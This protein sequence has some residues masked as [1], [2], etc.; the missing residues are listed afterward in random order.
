M[1]L[2]LVVIQS[3]CGCSSDLLAYPGAFLLGIIYHP[4]SAEDNAKLYEHVKTMVDSY[5]LLHPECLVL[6]T[7]DFNPTS[8]NIAPTPFKRSC[9]LTQIINVLTRDSGILD[10]CL[11][12]LEL[13]YDLFLGCTLY[14]GFV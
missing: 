10:W 8:T 4:P 14:A 7:G 6:V 2:I 1:L 3:N 5:T 9:G 11:T 12:K 13:D